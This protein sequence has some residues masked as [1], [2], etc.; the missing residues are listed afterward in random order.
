MFDVF[1]KVLI[2]ITDLA[3]F[4]FGKSKLLLSSTAS[5]TNVNVP[6]V[7]IKVTHA[8]VFDFQYI[9]LLRKVFLSNEGLESSSYLCET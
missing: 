9:A 1:S 8:I 2:V 6:N 5:L 4:F 7:E 3:L